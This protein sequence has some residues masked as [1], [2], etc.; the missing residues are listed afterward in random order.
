MTGVTILVAGLDGS[1]GGVAATR[2]AG[3]ALVD[4]RA[5]LVCAED[6]FACVDVRPAV[7]AATIVDAATGISIRC[8]TRSLICEVTT[9]IR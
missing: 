2:E 5:T 3:F 6:D 8:C 7:P 9:C 1:T 4:A